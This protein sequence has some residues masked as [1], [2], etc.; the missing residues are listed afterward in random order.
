MKREKVQS[1]ESDLD[2]GV[3]K[4]VKTDRLMPKKKDYRMRAHI[5]PLNSTP[6][7]IPAHH[8]YVDW[9]AH[10]PLKFGGDE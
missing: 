4:T 6:F 7:P 1:E 5:N 2:E 3:R 8:T 9:R 10:Y